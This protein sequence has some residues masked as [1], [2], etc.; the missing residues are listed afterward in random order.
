V[1]RMI[2]TVN[3]LGPTLIASIPEHAVLDAVLTES[4]VAEVLAQI[5]KSSIQKNQS[6][7]QDS[8]TS[9]LDINALP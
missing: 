3:R 6:S 4:Q 7:Q 2:A 1:L 9:I 8:A 5:L